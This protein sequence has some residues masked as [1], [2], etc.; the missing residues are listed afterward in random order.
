MRP[1]PE[2]STKEEIH[3]HVRELGWSDED[4]AD[5]GE[6]P[7]QVLFVSNRPLTQAEEEYALTLQR[8]LEERPLSTKELEKT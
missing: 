5:A 8:D 3:A 1:D 2:N 6:I 4:I 7:W